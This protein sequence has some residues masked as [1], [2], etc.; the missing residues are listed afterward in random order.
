MGKQNRMFRRIP[1]ETICTSKWKGMNQIY[2]MVRKKAD[3]LIDEKPVSAVSKNTKSKGQNSPAKDQIT[4]KG[5]PKD[6]K[7]EDQEVVK[8][9]AK[10]QHIGLEE[11]ETGYRKIYDSNA[12][13]ESCISNKSVTE[14]EETGKSNSLLGK[15]QF[16]DTK[17]KFIRLID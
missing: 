10:G 7:A 9:E 3:Q 1:E 14:S 15:R 6:E 12:D 13:H 4:D 17:M 2:D 11:N 8:V 5:K 16:R